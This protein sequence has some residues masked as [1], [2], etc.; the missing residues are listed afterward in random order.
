M[1]FVYSGAADVM[2]A[3][4]PYSMHMCGPREAIMRMLLRKNYG[5]THFIVGRD[6]AGTKSTLSGNDF[7]GAFDAKQAVLEVAPKLGMGVVP[8]QTMVIDILSL[9]LQTPKP[10]PVSLGLHGN[11]WFCNF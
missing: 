1:L 10:P 5:A 4:L 6:M 11:L 7:Y 2:W 9:L 3:Q 8:F